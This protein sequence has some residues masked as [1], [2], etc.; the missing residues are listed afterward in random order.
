MSIALVVD[1]ACDLPKTILD[2]RGIV[3]FPIS[4]Q[5]DGQYYTDDK[6]PQKMR[7]FYAKGLLT[8]EHSA[9]SIPYSS[10]QM[11]HIFMQDVVPNYDFA[12]VQTV[13]KQRSAIFDNCSKAQPK[14]LQS[15][16]ELKDQG[17]T[18]RHFGMRI[19]N[20][21]TL[22][23]G[24]GLLALFTSD[25]IE[26]GRSKQDITRL[27]EAFKEKIYAYA[28][29]PDV[30]YIRDRARKRGENSLGMLGAL[31][32]KSLDIKPIIQAKNDETSPVAK[33]RGFSNAA[34]RLFSYALEQMDRGLLSPYIVVSY[35]GDIA[36]L[37]KFERFK[38]LVEQ[39]KAKGINLVV[40]T[41]GLTSG[42]NLG[43][44]AISLALAAEEHSFE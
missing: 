29:P 36:D 14:I 8:M 20:S 30:A 40:C 5:V 13:S 11:Q 39:S 41:M 32:A 4:I 19:M 25:L 18:D 27:A 21:S 28:L 43:P 38:A 33:I 3:L 34:N 9:E 31:V 10:E 26:R 16:R 42:L 23:T 24:Q 44:G 22:F 7:D 17:D 2:E 6:D 37:A 1:A 15:Y 35:A 12:I